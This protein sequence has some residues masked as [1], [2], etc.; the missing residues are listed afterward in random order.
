VQKRLLF[1]ALLLISFGGSAQVYIKNL[2]AQAANPY[3]ALISWTVGAGS[4]ACSGMEVHWSLDSFTT[5]S[6]MVYTVPTICGASGVDENYDFTHTNPDIHKKNYYRIYSS[7]GGYSSIVMVDF[8]AINGNYNIFPDPIEDNTYLTFDNPN[9]EQYILDIAN[10]KGNRVYYTQ[11]NVTAQIQLSKSWFDA[12]V[13]F[14]RLYSVSGNII[15]GK[16]VVAK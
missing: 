9:N 3:Q 5:T 15:R 11:Y 6:S 1:Y 12:G 14:F 4:V 2:K 13:Y 7:Q 16:F 8:G 10:A